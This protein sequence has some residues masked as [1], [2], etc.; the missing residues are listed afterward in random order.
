[1][2]RPNF[3]PGP[4]ELGLAGGGQGKGD[5][6]RSPGWRKH[7]DEIDWP[8]VASTAGVAKAVDSTFHRRGAKLIKCYG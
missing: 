4:A 3:N 8:S 6:D 1:M 5:K 7:Y 2:K